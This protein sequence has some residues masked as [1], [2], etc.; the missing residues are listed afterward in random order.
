MSD[1]I[2]IGYGDVGRVVAKHLKRLGISFVVVDI[3]E[4]NFR[5]SNLRYMVGDAT[6]E[7][8]LIEAGVEKALLLLTCLDED[9]KNIYTTLIAR[10]LNPK[11]IIYSRINSKDNVDKAYKAGANYVLCLST[12]AGEMLARVILAPEYAKAM[13]EPIKLPEGSALYKYVVSETSPLVGKTLKESGIREETGCIVMGIQT[14]SKLVKL[15][16]GEE[17]IEPNSILLLFGSAENIKKFK[18]IF[19]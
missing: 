18:E 9:I 13:E 6:R 5:D 3:E 10:K 11:L 14:D 12:I 19:G 1:V 17:I 15:P 8:T 2:L 16:K 4:K 7:K